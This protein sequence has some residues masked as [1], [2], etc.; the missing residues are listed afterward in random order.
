MTCQCRP[1]TIIPQLIINSELLHL[2]SR[3][4]NHSKLSIGN[5]RIRPRQVTCICLYKNKDGSTHMI[6][7]FMRQFESL[8]IVPQS[9][10]IGV[11]YTHFSLTHY[12]CIT[13]YRVNRDSVYIRNNGGVYLITY[14]YYLPRKKSRYIIL[15][16]TIILNKVREKLALS[17]IKEMRQVI[18][19]RLK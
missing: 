14:P 4:L 12:R 1:N 7:L 13:D 9:Y 2:Q 10:L 18:P 11:T 16:T 6:H 19:P 8:L 3:E 5:V 17:L 15:V